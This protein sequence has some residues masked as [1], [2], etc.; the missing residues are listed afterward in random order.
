ML[1]MS[2]LVSDGYVLLGL[3]Y[4]FRLSCYLGGIVI[5]QPFFQKKKKGA[6][7]VHEKNPLQTTLSLESETSLK[8]NKSYLCWYFLTLECFT[9]EVKP[10]Q[11]VDPHSLTASQTK[12]FLVHLLCQFFFYWCLVAQTLSRPCFFP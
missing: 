10:A 4:V 12:N 1:E 7:S 6:C 3:C 8:K 9:F 11:L 2:Y 5:I